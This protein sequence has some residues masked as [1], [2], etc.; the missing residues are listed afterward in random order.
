[1]VE[2]ILIVD[3]ENTFRKVFC[4]VLEEA[5]YEVSDAPDGPTAIA[6]I[7]NQD[8][9][10][11]LCDLNLPGGMDGLEVLEQ[12]TQLS[13]QTSVLIITAYG[14]LETAVEA[15]RKGAYDYILKPIIFEDIIL[16]VKRL[17]ERKRLVLENQWLKQELQ[18]KYDFHNIIGKSK[19]MQG[20]YS[21]LEKIAPTNSNV[22]IT[23]ESGTGKELVARA[24]HYNSLR[25]N[26]KFVTVECGT[27]PDDLLES[28]LFGHV[29]G[30]F[31]SAIRDKD[32]L[33]GV[34]EGG[35]LF[36][37]EIGDLSPGLQAK[38]LRSIE[39]R[40]IRPVGATIPIKIDIRL[41][42]ATNINMPEAVKEGRFREDLFYRLN[43]IEV[44]IP[45][46]RERKDDIPLL[47]RHF[48]TKYNKQL[49]RDFK[50]VDNTVM[51]ALLS[52]D[53]QGNVRELENVIE[54]AM[55]LGEGEL[56]T[57]QNLPPHITGE[58]ETPGTSN[59]LKEAMRV[60]ERQHIIK[61]LE[62]ANN[63]KRQAAA[64]LEIGLSSLYRKMENLGIIADEIP[65]NE[66]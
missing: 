4:S 16:K 43:V 3:D 41:I 50:A 24:I 64:M 46:L 33:F 48:I 28:E 56:I 37:D 66:N 19:P 14:T 60:Y 10:V 65:K 26:E 39:E 7:R 17:L 6:M 23:G 31:T 11:A 34:A 13:P 35:T 38:L 42:A 61:T 47:V 25:R 57:L 32:G 8:I 22:L 15:L 9:S 58:D 49:S 51:R 52:N 59:C 2:R 30:A 20:V 40:E 5:G 54:R 27:I 21:L 45:P 1:M 36:L 63:D 29:K 55:V 12:I 53:W 18:Q 44:N 62:E